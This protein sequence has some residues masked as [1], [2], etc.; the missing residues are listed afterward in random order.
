[1]R[2]PRVAGNLWPCVAVRGGSVVDDFFW[3]LYIKVLRRFMWVDFFCEILSEILEIR[4]GNPQAS[5]NL[6][7]F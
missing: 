1:M 5:L 7:P 2:N 4:D 3:V 6:L